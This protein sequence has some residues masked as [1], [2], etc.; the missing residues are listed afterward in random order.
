MDRPPRIPILCKIWALVSDAEVFKESEARRACSCCN[1]DVL[2]D[3][4]VVAIMKGE[5]GGLFC[6]IRKGTLKYQR[7]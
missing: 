3:A 1:S 7:E 2:E 4:L 6:Q 5:A